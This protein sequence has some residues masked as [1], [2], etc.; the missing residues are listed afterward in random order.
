MKLGIHLAERGLLPDAVI[1]WGIR[2]TLAA[3]LDALAGGAPGHRA[4]SVD[5]RDETTFAELANQQHYDVPPA[6]F[7]AVLGSRMKYSCG[8]WDS[9][10]RAVNL[11]RSEERMLELTCARAS[12]ED[13]MKILDLGCGWGALSLWIAE[14]YPN[15]S[16][17]SISN[18]G[19]Q[20]AYIQ[21]QVQR[22]G[23]TNVLV[24]TADVND[25]KPRAC[26][27]LVVSVEMF[28]HLRDPGSLLKHIAGW[29]NPGGRLFLHHFC[30]A[31]TAYTYEIQSEAA[32]M[33]RHF[34]TGGTMPARETVA[35]ATAAM[36]PVA[37]WDVGGEHYAKTCRA[38][39]QRLDANWEEAETALRAR[40]GAKS[41][42][43]LQRW[44]MFFM[45]C[46]EL[47][48]Y[49]GG[50]EWFVVHHL[51]EPAR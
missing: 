21:K 38:W 50:A 11:D 10:D 12:I 27:D 37:S 22:R 1:R 28:E 6:F 19:Q 8:Y 14:R 4:A 9:G 13:G 3:R 44:R 51:M 18:A 47:F 34:F 23:L 48:A 33:A 31:N 25:W 36:V 42:T 24:E 45:A 5:A 49:R 20:G 32:W 16:V 15:C 46:E 2:S 7:A 30:H 40:F 43:A 41:A 39:L 17:H 26:F 29:L 35:R